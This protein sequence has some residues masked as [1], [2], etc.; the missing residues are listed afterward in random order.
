M[1]IVRLRGEWL[2]VTFD[3]NL[4]ITHALNQV[5]ARRLG[6][7]KWRVPLDA[8]DDFVGRT[9]GL[10]L[11]W[12]GEADELRRAAL[13][14]EETAQGEDKL[15]VAIKAGTWQGSWEEPVPLL[16]HQRVGVDFL[17]SRRGC[18]LCDEQGLGKTLTCL[19]AF[20]LLRHQ[21]RVESLLVVCPNSL[22]HNWRSEAAKFF[23]DWVVSVAEGY[24]GRRRRAYESKAD[25]FVV[26]YESARSDYADLRLLLRR[27]RTVLVCDESH[28]V[29]TYGS[30]TTKGL[31]F[32]RSAA[33]R[34]WIMSG[35]PIPNSLEDAYAQAELAGG[36]RLLGSRKQFNEAF[37]KASET[38]G[39]VEQLRDRLEPIMLRRTKEDALDLPDRTFE[40]RRV[41]LRGDQ[42]RI[43]EAIRDDLLEKV[44]HLTD[45]E[46]DAARM[47][48]LTRLLRLSQVASNPQLVFPDY[49]EE[50]AKRHELDQLLRDLI[51]ANGR[52]V[53]LW[54]Y[55]VPTITSFLDHY[56]DYRPVAIYG[57]VPPPERAKAVQAFQED[58][59]TMLFIG[60]PQAAGTGL[61][62]T[63]AHYAVYESLTWRYDLYAQSLDRI[64][65]IG[66]SK[67]VT[68]F[69]V[70]AENTVDIDILAN[71]NKKRAIAATV[72]GDDEQENPEIDRS[73][74]IAML[75]GR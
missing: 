32:L 24:K 28:L 18:L 48:F 3:H 41:E 66:Q 59:S 61:T 46:F 1:G 30:Q 39:A 29:K 45:E 22:K 6:H 65:R 60:N 36:A 55:Y 16:P 57:A 19:V 58:P 71:L 7:G 4:R 11:G 72:L 51:V 70:L 68:Y 62:L 15:S 13:S 14:E 53:V 75:A 10:A 40:E 74:F 20:W 49:L 5:G 35:T 50:N 21:E 67:N 56:A 33:E 17:T 23:P 64:H 25:I 8:L 52:K 69:L 27:R 34:V 9:D 12:E 26:N 38:L 42:R 54:S 2:E 31:R 47:N 37:G 63:A 44:R 43:Y 73:E